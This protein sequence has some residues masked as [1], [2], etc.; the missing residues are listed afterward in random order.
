MPDPV[1]PAGVLSL[2]QF[3]AMRVLLESGEDRDGLIRRAGLSAGGWQQTHRH[4][5]YRATEENRMGGD[6]LQSRFAD[7]RTT[8]LAA[9]EAG[10]DILDMVGLSSAPPEEPPVKSTALPF[11]NVSAM[12]APVATP[13]AGGVPSTEDPP[14]H[15][16]PSPLPFQ[17]PIPAATP[18]APAPPRSPISQTLESE[19]AGGGTLDEEDGVVPPPV[20]PFRPSD[21]AELAPSSTLD[22][23]DRPVPAALPFSPKAAPA[24][25]PPIDETLAIDDD[26]DPLA[27]TVAVA[28]HEQR[29]P[30][31]TLDQFASLSAEIAVAPAERAAI[32]LRYGLDAE[33]AEA[34]RRTWALR[35]MNDAVLG[36]DYTAKMRAFREWLA[37]RKR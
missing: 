3:T 36:R 19:D 2:E 6:E 18:F 11:T 15:K 12:Q 30:T 32:E 7:E 4:W 29:E 1:K 9:H 28:P 20:L 33:S 22:R 5:L 21:L 37:S 16:V 14:M 25:P 26:D 8:L 10:D 13:A 35:F 17:A 27:G 31:L 34:E 23:E 24:V